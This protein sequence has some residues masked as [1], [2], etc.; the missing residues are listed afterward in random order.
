VARPNP[1]TG[2]VRSAGILAGATS[3]FGPNHMGLFPKK[4]F[5]LSYPPGIEIP[6]FLG[7]TMF[8]SFAGGR[9]MGLF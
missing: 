8:S 7:K 1:K 4:S 3:V 2:V 9:H 5:L 6:V